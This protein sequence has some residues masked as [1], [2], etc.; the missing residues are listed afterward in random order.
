MEYHANPRPRSVL[1][2]AGSDPSGG[3]GI[4]ADLKTFMDHRTYGMSII[5]A[6]TVQNTQSVQSVYPIPTEL[7]K[8]QLQSIRD[9]LPIDAIKIGMIGDH[10]RIHALAD[11]FE[12]WPN[13][14]PIVL[15]PV[16]MAKDG[17]AL[18]S[19]NA[20]HTLRTRLIPL[21]TILTPNAPEAEIIGELPGVT[22]LYKGGHIPGPI[23]TD[24]LIHQ[25]QMYQYQHP[26]IHSPHT[27]GTGCTLSSAIAANLA[28]G[29]SIENACRA[30]SAYIATL[31]QR[32]HHS[33][34]HGHGPLLH[35]DLL[36]SHAL[37]TFR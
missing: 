25:G 19:P 34:G 9:D 30:G 29:Q 23:V 2:I 32:A 14:P 35:G 26:R 13:R 15:D 11:I 8:A 18:I 3:A 4:Q 36:I 7:I 21:I 31:L 28:H 6:L 5:T 17:T 12:N 27:H 22:V 1:S 24:T 10:E 33:I 20:L 16:M 37:S